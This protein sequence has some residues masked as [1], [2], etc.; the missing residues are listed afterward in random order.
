MNYTL[1]L[2]VGLTQV[3]ND[4]TNQYLY[5][6]GRIAQVNT[7]TE[8]FLG[9]ALGSVRQ[10]TNSNGDIT[11]ARAYE[12]YGNLA[13]ANGTA[14]TN[15]GFTSEYTD[16]SGKVYLR[17]RYYSSDV[18]RFLSKDPSRLENNLYSYVSSNPINRIDPTGLFSPSTIAESYGFS[19]FDKLLDAFD[20]DQEPFNGKRWGWLAL[21]LDAKP[22]DKFESYYL[23]LQQTYPSMS[24]HDSGFFELN[25]NKIGV[26]VTYY[27][28]TGGALGLLP[29][30]SYA[31]VQNNKYGS[32][33]WFWRDNLPHKYQLNGIYYVDHSLVRD[34]PDYRTVN[35]PSVPINLDFSG[36]FGIAGG[37]SVIVDRFGNK[38]AA[39]SLGSGVGLNLGSY[40]ESYVAADAWTALLGYRIYPTE[41]ELKSIA[42]CATISGG[43]IIYG[44]SV[45]L[46]P[47]QFSGFM[48]GR[49]AGIITYSTGF[50]LS[51]SDEFSYPLVP[52]GKDT[53]MGWNNY[54]DYRGFGISRSDVERKAL[55]QLGVCT[56]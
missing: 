9:D 26:N 36:G 27:S 55:L 29:M 25:N 35:L 16:P 38:Y 56:P 24:L 11:L 15:Y 10:L 12:P 39:V 40:S 37:V 21:L 13:Q 32:T 1:D 43:V 2:N 30:Q 5:G 45:G 49:V 31:F 3:L 23:N 48:P 19:S 34:L 42:L 8:Y 14:Q 52:L 46:C 7:T 41:E 47:Y 33:Y 22:G 28:M 18:G 53:S 17:A 54:L 50:N 51:L 44:G 6:V 20:R 4:G